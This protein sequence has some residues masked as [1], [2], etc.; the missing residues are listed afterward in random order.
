MQSRKIVEIEILDAIISRIDPFYEEIIQ[1]CISFNSVYW[2]QGRY[3]KEKKEYLKK[4]YEIKK[5]SMLIG[6]G[7]I[8]RVCD[9]L[10]H[11]GIKYKIANENPIKVGS[12]LKRLEHIVN[13]RNGDRITLREDQVEAVT[14]ALRQER[15]IIKAATGVGKSYIMLGIMRC[16]DSSEN[17][18]VLC[19]T[20]SIIKQLYDEFQNFFRSIVMFGGDVDSEEKFKP[21]KKQVVLSTIQS[22]SMIDPKEYSD[23]FSAVLVD[24]SHRVSSVSGNYAQVLSNLLAPIRLGFTATPPT[25]QE[26]I[27]SYERYLGPV[28]YEFGINE[29]SK[30]EI[31]A[32]PHIIIKKAGFPS[33][34]RDIRDYHT[35][36]YEG[37][38][39][40]K[41]RNMQIVEI[42]QE[43]I[44]RGETVLIF[45]NKIEHGT[46]ILSIADELGIE[47]AFVQGSS[48]TE[49]RE[50][51]KHELDNGVT[52][53]VIATSVWKEGVN[54]RSLN[55]VIN[56]GGGKSEIQTLQC[57]GRGLRITD[58]KKVVNIYDFFDSGNPY[59]IAHFG[60]RMILYFNQGWM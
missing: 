24:E 29:A 41:S 14:M 48:T 7:L 51:V 10:K 32:K 37:I 57:I 28:I 30:I 25:A 43:C 11:K 52:K 33:G 9:Y 31:L 19:H 23:Y 21:F 34:L 15:G 27:F 36:Y 17:I 58:E 46:N 8:P 59:L 38:V 47:I 6:T 45:V 42:V 26:A 4:C 12:N 20:T 60:E 39:A 56:A 2:T 13:K 18:L 35:V 54:I 53:A 44:T 22:F 55:N 50:R 1:P 40:N 16:L 49:I 3:K 5:R